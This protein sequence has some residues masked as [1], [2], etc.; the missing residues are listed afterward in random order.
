MKRLIAFA[1]L[2]CLTAGAMAAITEVEGMKVENGKIS[3]SKVFFANGNSAAELREML[4]GFLRK[5][6]CDV[7]PGDVISTRMKEVKID[8]TLSGMTAMETPYYISQ[9]EASF[10]VRIDVKDGKYRVTIDNFTLRSNMTVG[11]YGGGMGM[12]SNGGI[13][14]LEQMALKKNRESFRQGQTGAMQAYSRTLTAM[15]EQATKVAE[16]DDNW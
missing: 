4:A 13:I 5:R 10:D 3:Y 12:S 11:F 1:L 14:P 2:A 6:G 9:G 16:R 8:P 7:V 15:F